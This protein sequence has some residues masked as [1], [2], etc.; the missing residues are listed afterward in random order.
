MKKHV[1]NKKKVV[2]KLADEKKHKK[3]KI[4]QTF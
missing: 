4:N 1:L 2:Q 3:V